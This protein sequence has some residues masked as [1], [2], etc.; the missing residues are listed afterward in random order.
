MSIGSKQTLYYPQAIESD[1][2]GFFISFS[3][4]CKIST[5]STI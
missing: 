2:G 5:I 4:N 1:F 3:K